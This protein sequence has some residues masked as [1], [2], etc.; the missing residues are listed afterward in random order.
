MMRLLLPSLLTEAKNHFHNSHN[1]F[2][3]S[4]VQSDQNILS[5]CSTSQRDENP[6]HNYRISSGKRQKGDLYT[7]QSRLIDSVVE[8]KDCRGVV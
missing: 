3:D 6:M 1:L 8:S 5:N 4:S 7:S 2:S